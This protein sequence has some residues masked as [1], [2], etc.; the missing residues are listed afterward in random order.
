MLLGTASW[1]EDFSVDLNRLVEIDSTRPMPTYTLDRVLRRSEVERGS[2]MP[3]RWFDVLI[4]FNELG[5]VRLA[6]AG[7]AGPST[8]KYWKKDMTFRWGLANLAGVKG[9]WIRNS[10]DLFIIAWVDEPDGRGNGNSFSHGY[11]IVQLQHRRVQVLLRGRCAITARLRGGVQEYPLGYSR[12]SFDARRG[13]LEERVTRFHERASDRPHDLSHPMNDEGGKDIFVAR[14]NET[15]TLKYK[16]ANGELLPRACSLSYHTQKQD[17]LSEIARFY[18]GPYA[19][20][21]VLLEADAN[22][23]AKYRRNPPGASIYFDEGTE[24]RVPVPEKWLIDNFGHGLILK[25][26]KDRREQVD[27]PNDGSTTPVYNSPWGPGTN[28]TSGSDQRLD[29]PEAEASVAEKPENRSATTASELAR[30]RTRIDQLGLQAS[31]DITLERQRWQM[32]KQYLAL[33]D[34]LQL[35]APLSLTREEFDSYLRFRD[36]AIEKEAR[37]WP[38]SE[39]VTRGGGS[40]ASYGGWVYL[41][42]ERGFHFEKLIPGTCP[43]WIDEVAPPTRCYTFLPTGS[44][45]GTEMWLVDVDKGRYIGRIGELT[46]RINN[47]PVI[48]PSG[49]RFVHIVNPVT[50]SDGGCYCIGFFERKSTGSGEP[51][52]ASEKIIYETRD[53]AVYHLRWLNEDTIEFEVRPDHGRVERRVKI[54][55]MVG[56]SITAHEGAAGRTVR[57]GETLK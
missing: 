47:S 11:V 35:S 17:E 32:V 25:Q 6:E 27:S 39:V 3:E 2:D 14:I 30:L 54:P 26:G 29:R 15:I 31:Q 4:H 33:V 41:K 16:L 7:E 21:S 9:A 52:L 43:Q 40:L 50:V 13:L 46:M 18:L 1:A 28:R 49:Q 23:A 24:I 5:D 42:R 45:S 22:L 36:E 38:N 19:T 8:G 51:V 10:P 57:K 48:S 12:F 20:R 53:G 44:E 55:A 37:Q 56:S 34:S